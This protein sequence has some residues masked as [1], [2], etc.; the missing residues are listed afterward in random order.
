MSFN[1]SRS[2]CVRS[3]VHKGRRLGYMVSLGPQSGFL[4]EDSVQVP[5]VVQVTVV[6]VSGAGLPWRSVNLQSSSSC[7]SL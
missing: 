6:G 1:Y 3:C 2:L 5:K 4:F 7:C